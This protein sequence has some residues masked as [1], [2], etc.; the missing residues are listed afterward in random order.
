MFDAAARAQEYNGKT[1][2]EREQQY[3]PALIRQ[4]EAMSDDDL[5]VAG[6]ASEPLRLLVAHVLDQRHRVGCISELIL[7]KVEQA[8]QAFVSLPDTET[9]EKNKA[10]ETIKDSDQ[11]VQ[12]CL[13]KVPKRYQIFSTLTHIAAKIG[14]IAMLR[15]LVGLGLPVDVHDD[16]GMLPIHWAAKQDHQD[17]VNY[18]IVSHGQS[19]QTTFT[20]EKFRPFRYVNA[21]YFACK[22]PGQAI[23]NAN[24]G[25]I[26][27]GGERY[28]SKDQYHRQ[29]MHYTAMSGN[30][31]V[32]KTLVGRFSHNRNK[33]AKDK[34]G[35]TS[36]LY[37]VASG[38]VELAQYCQT[39]MGCRFNVRD[40][41]GREAIHYAAAGQSVAMVKHCVSQRNYIF[42][43]DRE[44][45]SAI[46]IAGAQGSAAVFAELLSYDNSKLIAHH[47][48]RLPDRDKHG[49]SPLHH[50]FA[51]G[52]H[53]VAQFLLEQHELARMPAG[54]VRS[55]S[56]DAERAARHQITE[57]K[58]RIDNKA[59]AGE[60]YQR[61][62]SHD[63]GD[64]SVDKV[65]YHEGL[66]VD[67]KHYQ[68]FAST[69]MA[70]SP[71]HL[72]ALNGHRAV[73]WLGVQHYPEGQY[74][75][76][77]DWHRMTDVQGRNLLQCAISSGNPELIHGIAEKMLAAEYQPKAQTTLPDDTWCLIFG[78][79]MSLA[80]L[81]R[82][83]KVN[84]QFS[85]VVK[86]V[87]SE[88]YGHGRV[89]QA[90]YQADGER[91]F[92]PYQYRFPDRGMRAASKQYFA[93]LPRHLD[94]IPEPILRYKLLH[95]VAQLGDLAY[96]QQ[97]VEN[98]SFAV[99][100][101]DEDGMLPIHHAAAHDHLDIVLYCEKV[102]KQSILSTYTHD[103][104][105]LAYHV[106][107]FYFSCKFSTE[108]K[109]AKY[110][111][112]KLG[113]RKLASVA[114][115]LDKNKRNLLHYASL[116]GCIPMMQVLKDAGVDIHQ[117]D[118]AEKSCMHFAAQ[119][120]N[121]KAIR[122]CVDWGL[123]YQEDDLAEQSPLF[124]TATS[125]DWDSTAYL[126]AKVKQGLSGKNRAGSRMV[127]KALEREHGLDYVKTLERFAP[128]AV[129]YSGSWRDYQQATAMIYA[130]RSGS[131]ATLKFLIE[132]KSV[133]FGPA[134]N[135]GR[136]P[137]HHCARRGDLS[138]WQYLLSRY[139]SK[140]QLGQSLRLH[141][142]NFA[143]N[144]LHYAC[145]SQQLPIML[146]IAK[147]YPDLLDRRDHLANHPACYIQS[148]SLYHYFQSLL[149]LHFWQPPFA[150]V[151]E[152]ET[153][154]QQ[155]Q[156]N[157][158]NRQDNNHKVQVNHPIYNTL[159]WLENKIS[160]AESIHLQP[161]VRARSLPI[162][163]TL[164]RDLGQ[165]WH[166]LLAEKRNDKP[167][168]Q[169]DTGALMRKLEVAV[170]QLTY[171]LVST[172]ELRFSTS[173]EEKNHQN[174]PKKIGVV[175]PECLTIMWGLGL[176]F[177]KTYG[178]ALP[179]AQEAV[180]PEN[181]VHPIRVQ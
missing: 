7:T 73:F 69:V 12:D 78:E 110:T 62:Y 43:V 171:I 167:I 133:P 64:E 23:V 166:D 109:V 122:E 3:L 79:H 155:Y 116:A 8:N 59:K 49:M 31:T 10:L 77:L 85:R 91:F 159:V 140:Q 127:F 34:F 111:L 16:Q 19:L 177:D 89:A 170:C 90:L 146:S 25:Q 46:H 21:W 147:A 158:L 106:N 66:L 169:D 181:Q 105:R 164:A 17:I 173:L 168:S 130:A 175:V 6:R 72:A 113:Q 104:Y 115:K 42:G 26:T 53:E 4:L 60:E 156:D 76:P 120:G 56:L 139:L 176:Q 40:N 124:L 137:L 44:G 94:V 114:A 70:P 143:R 29:P 101:F 14:D 154:L 161:N 92:I 98:G 132:E 96:F 88:E 160:N 86:R 142:D 163:Q 41:Q 144:V 119:S 45:M 123:S 108:F 71:L 30:L 20:N 9:V 179:A 2:Q 74:Y 84:K 149:L 107:G 24:I 93:K 32:M 128:D 81:Q 141:T 97:L 63:P 95:R 5:I 80:D 15:V 125:G 148:V 157:H 118:A 178:E 174:F 150:G 50:A 126:F 151:G 11:A 57:R 138:A 37:A 136:S 68:G 75:N 134:D 39:T 36:L 112:E 27:A 165:M 121:A 58:W 47:R 13:Q 22:A 54:Y 82:I 28:L 48:F 67:N 35:A 153:I 131:E 33:Q 52:N 180:E 145:Q 1:A 38:S 65:I 129:D 83:A 103:R 87:I 51:E 100:E 162:L 117:K 61:D 152:C 99:N 172:P 18:L 135:K 102:H 55:L